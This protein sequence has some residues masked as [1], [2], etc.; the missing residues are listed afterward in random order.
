M[1]TLIFY[2]LTH[3][4][5]MFITLSIFFLVSSCYCL[6]FYCYWLVIVMISLLPPVI[7]F[8]FACYVLVTFAIICYHLLPLTIL[9]EHKMEYYIYRFQ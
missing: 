9:I 2:L 3:N 5:S 4:V 8:W 6:V 7:N 1:G